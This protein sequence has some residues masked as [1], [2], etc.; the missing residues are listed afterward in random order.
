MT[1]Q[2]RYTIELEQIAQRNVQTAVSYTGAAKLIW[3]LAAGS[4]GWVSMLR[5]AGV[6][7]LLALYWVTVTTTLY[8]LLFGSLFL[9][10][11][12]LIYT[13]SRRHLIRDAPSVIS[14]PDQRIGT[15]SISNP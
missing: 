8:A 6:A 12:W 7:V 3:P 13:Q 2:A 11:P 10:F 5:H 14:I 9:W 4:R 15:D 1:T